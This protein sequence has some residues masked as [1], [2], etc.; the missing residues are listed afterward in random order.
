[1]VSSLVKLLPGKKR[2]SLLLLWDFAIA[3]GYKNFPLWS[4]DSFSIEVYSFLCF[5]QNKFYEQ[6]VTSVHLSFSGQT[7]FFQTT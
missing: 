6:N 4:P 3:V 2:K 7:W 1:M 5:T